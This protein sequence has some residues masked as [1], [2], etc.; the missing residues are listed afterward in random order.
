M[1]VPLWNIGSHCVLVPTQRRFGNMDFFRTF[2]SDTI[3]RLSPVG[4]PVAKLAIFLFYHSL[5]SRSGLGSKK[6]G[7]TWL[8]DRANRRS[9]LS[10]VIHFIFS[11]QDADTPTFIPSSSAVPTIP[12]VTIHS[13]PNSTT[14]LP[15]LISTDEQ[16]GLDST[17][18]NEASDNDP[19][20]EL[21]SAAGLEFLA[22]NSI[23]DQREVPPVNSV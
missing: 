9:L 19:T 12:Q 15:N 1:V 2:F 23:E 6:L 14:Y 20:V 5:G 21:P 7:S 8:H 22:D 18:T 16:V 13:P 10:D 17:S 11:N 3:E 4:N